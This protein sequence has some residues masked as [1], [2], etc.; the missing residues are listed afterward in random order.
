MLLLLIAVC[1]ALPMVSGWTTPFDRT[2]TAPAIDWLPCGDFPWDTD[3]VTVSCDSTYSSH[4]EHRQGR[5]TVTCPAD[6]D[7]LVGPQI[8]YDGFYYCNVRNSTWMGS[9]PVCLAMQIGVHHDVSRVHFFI[10]K[11]VHCEVRS[12]YKIYIL[13]VCLQHLEELVKQS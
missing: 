13:K 2:T 7:M 3:G 5:C 10:W 6:A 8:W 12:Q 11:Y 9:E 1:A 4:Y